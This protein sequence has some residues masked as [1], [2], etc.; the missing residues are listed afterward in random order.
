MIKQINRLWTAVTRVVFLAVL[1]AGLLTSCVE[2]LDEGDRPIV[3]PNARELTIRIYVPGATPATKA[4]TGDVAGVSPESQIYGVQVWMFNHHAAGVAT[5][6]DETAV[7]YAEVTN[8]N[9]APSSNLPG[10]G[11]YTTDSGRWTDGSIYELP[12]RIPGYVLDRPD[13]QM[14]FDFYVLANGASIGSP[15]ARTMTRSQLKALTF[16]KTTDADWF[17][18]TNPKAGTTP[19]S[20]LGTSGLPISGFFN[21]S[22]SDTGNAASGVDLRFIKPENLK[23]LQ[24]QTGFDI[25]AL[26]PVVQLERAVSKIRFAFA[27]PTGMND[28]Q[29]TK[30]VID[31]ELIPTSTFVFPREDGT[32]FKLPNG[33]GYTTG[34]A[35]IGSDD[36]PLFVVPKNY[37]GSDII[38]AVSDPEALKSDSEKKLTTDQAKTPSE[39]DAQEYDTFLSAH[40]TSQIAYLRESGKPITGKI[41]YKIGATSSE[42][43]FTMEGLTNTNFHR[44]HSWI[45]YAYFQGGGLHIKP[46]VVADWVYDY[47]SQTQTALQYYEYLQK[48]SARVAFSDDSR[49]LFGYGYTTST[50]NDWRRYHPTAKTEWYFRRQS[51]NSAGHEF[52]PSQPA[53]VSYYDWDDWVNSQMI[54]APGKNAANVPMY[55]NRIELRTNGFNYSYTSGG[56]EVTVPIPL[57][58]KVDNPQK[59]DIVLYHSGSNS[60]EVF[61]DG[62]AT[63]TSAVDKT[64]TTYFY[65][66]PKDSASEGDHTAAYLLT[67]PDVSTDETLK[68]SGLPQEKLP[69]NTS[70]FPGSEDNTEIFFYC[71]AL[72]TFQ[73]FYT[74][75]NDPNPLPQNV[76]VYGS[77]VITDLP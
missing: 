54:V 37:T 40:S 17:G 26:S 14:R 60:Y 66:V 43:P 22:T 46:V 48:G 38:A 16:G 49:S 72:S 65:I 4:G 42:A 51:W 27:R 44:N 6:D 11:Y 62:K 63:F 50:G 52:D 58:L 9:W 31:G 15:A 55:A 56:N 5:G 64:T 28:I 25:K 61:T 70:V 10:S 36:S 33:S 68:N 59:F 23:T 29:I 76:K 35:T 69:F 75:A 74:P 41:Y 24:Q 32:E 19:L 3:D 57:T 73:G 12:L 34:A 7:S 8:L 47:N 45:V 77:N 18:T 21:K 13:A 53:G 30:I 2:P 1:S 67:D 39:M 20:A 71:V